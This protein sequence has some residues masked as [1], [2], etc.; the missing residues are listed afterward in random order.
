MLIFLFGLIDVASTICE[1]GVL[2]LNQT[3]ELNLFNNLTSGYNRIIQ[4]SEKVSI[5]VTASLKQILSIDEKQQIM[6]TSIHFSQQWIDQRLQWNPADFNGIQVTFIQ[7]NKIWLPDTVILN[8]AEGNGF[9]TINDFNLVIVRH[10]GQVYFTITSFQ[11]RTKCDL[12]IDAFPFDKQVC[13]ISFSSWMRASNR[14]DYAQNDIKL[15]TKGFIENQIWKLGNTSIYSKVDEDRNPFEDTQNTHIVIGI[16]LIRK[17]LFY[18][19][20]GV[21]PCLILNLVTLLSF[22]FPYVQQVT[23]NMTIFLTYA[24]YALRI[25]NDLPTQS[26]FVP[27][28]AIYFL[29]SIIFTLLAMIWFF[30]CNQMTTKKYV[31]ELFISIIQFIKKFSINF[32][33]KQN[34]S[35]IE[36]LPKQKDVEVN[37]DS[38]AEVEKNINTLNHLVVILFSIL[39]FFSIL[40]TWISIFQF[41]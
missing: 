24:V 6:I 19:I 26:D 4:P 40:A 21:F 37:E 5:N 38:D 22:M 34:K 10:D 32:K 39:Y 17:P 36:V 2:N 35:R 25:N 9:L 27:T 41:N 30:F 20:N 11:T 12:D 8:A 13:L 28:I 1:C 18:M 23:V 14:I 15:D 7:A 31:P 16:E 3:A 29:I 33:K